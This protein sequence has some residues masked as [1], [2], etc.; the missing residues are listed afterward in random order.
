LGSPAT[1][2]TTFDFCPSDRGRRIKNIICPRPTVLTVKGS[3]DVDDKN[4]L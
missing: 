1:K 2:R 3:K 4:N